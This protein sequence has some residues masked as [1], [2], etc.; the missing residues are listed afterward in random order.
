MVEGEKGDGDLEGGG[1]WAR[2][3]RGAVLRSSD[4]FSYKGAEQ[5][6]GIY[7]SGREV[8]CIGLM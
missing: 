7:I 3:E 2:L 1:G 5:E 6:G 4:D 8:E